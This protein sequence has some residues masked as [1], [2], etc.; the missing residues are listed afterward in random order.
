MILEKIKKNFV[1]YDY[2]FLLLFLICFFVSLILFSL[3]EFFFRYETL[4]LFAPHLKILPVIE[5][6]LSFLFGTFIS[7]YAIYIRDTQDRAATFLYGIGL[8][9][10]VMLMNIFLVNALQSTPFHPID[11]ILL[12][13]DQVLH[14]NTPAMMQ[15]ASQHRR[16]H[17]LLIYAYNFLSWELLLIPV[18]CFSLNAKKSTLIFFL[19]EML[20][21][22]VGGLIYYFFPTMAPSGIIHSYY[23]AAEQMNTS[24]RFFDVH[25]YIQA[26]STEG[27]LIAFPSFHV[28]WAVLL[29]YVARPVRWIFYL[30][31][32]VNLLVITST[33]VLGWHYGMDVVGG[34]MVAMLGI[35]FAEWVYQKSVLLYQ[36]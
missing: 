32:V 35:V 20:A 33:V 26:T 2:V 15:W 31:C 11:E 7:L 18:L 36:L 17:L 21:L 29:T 8:L 3:N 30:M 34:A 19:A 27:G 1:F 5:A 14:I 22:L 24:I 6:V 10:W 4:V 13:I 9:F 12:T 25:H 23:F 16:F 28:I